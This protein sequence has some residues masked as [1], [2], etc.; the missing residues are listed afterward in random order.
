MKYSSNAFLFDIP[1]K[2]F[3]Q[4]KNMLY[5]RDYHVIAYLNNIVYVFGG[6]TE[7]KNYT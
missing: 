6:C 3:I 5:P 1:N 4:M 2:E 7:A